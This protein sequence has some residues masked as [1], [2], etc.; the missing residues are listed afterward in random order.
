VLIPLLTFNFQLST[1]NLFSEPFH[2]HPLAGVLES[3]M[4]SHEA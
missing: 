1:F 3:E 4:N 2:L